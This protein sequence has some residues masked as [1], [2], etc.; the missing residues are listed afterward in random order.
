MLADGRTERTIARWSAAACATLS[1]VRLHRQ[2]NSMAAMCQ[3]KG[4]CEG[5]SL[6]AEVS[7]PTMCATATFA[8]GTTN[9]SGLYASS[10]LYALQRTKEHSDL[11][12]YQRYMLTGARLTCRNMAVMLASRTA[13]SST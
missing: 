12:T 1:G 3:P 4:A 10:G 11:Y 13:T 6:T 8:A 9:P 7:K 2:R 5:P